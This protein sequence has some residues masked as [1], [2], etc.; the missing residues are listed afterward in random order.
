MFGPVSTTEAHLAFSGERAHSNNTAEMTAMIEALSFL[1]SRGPVARDANSFFLRLQTCV[2]LGTIH[3]RSHVQL[4]LACQQAMLSIQHRLRLTMQH[5][6]G[7]TWVMNAPIMPP[8]LGHS[9]LCLIIT[10]PHVGLVITLIPLLVLVRATTLETSWKKCVTL[11]LKQH[12]HLRTG[13]S[14][15]FL[16]WLSMT[17]THALHHVW[18][19]LS[20]LSRAQP[21]YSTLL[22]LKC[23]LESPT[24][25][26]STTSS[27]GESFAHNMWNPLM[28][29]LFHEQISGAFEPFVDEIDLAKIALSCHFA[30]DVLCHKEGIHDSA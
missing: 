30:V 21:F 6:Y 29:L 3:A 10:L 13:I 22:Y 24:S 20:S 17:F 5:V 2:C 16:I 8:H 19:A 18:F 25:C 1:G 27:S 4:A 7:H 9:V 14:D 12:R 28:E 23:A 11:E 26:V 15:M